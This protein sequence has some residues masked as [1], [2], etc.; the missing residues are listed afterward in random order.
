MAYFRIELSNSQ[1]ECTLVGAKTKVAPQKPLSI[2]RME[3]QA[4][5]LGRRL[6][7]S[8]S[9]A[10]VLRFRQRVFLSDSTTVL[11]WI[12]SEARQFKPFVAFRVGEILE[13]SE[14]SEWRYVPTKLNVADIATKWRPD[15]D[16]SVSN[17]WFNGPEFLRCDESQWPKRV[18]VTKT[19]SDEEIHR[20]HHVAAIASINPNP[21]NISSWRILVRSQVQAVRAINLFMLKIRN[22]GNTKPLG[23]FTAIE[24][25]DAESELIRSVQ[26]EHFPVEK[27]CLT[28]GK[29]LPNGSSLLS[30]SPILDDEGLL[31]M[32]GRLNNQE[33]PTN[34]PIILPRDH[35]ITHLIMKNMHHRYHHHNHETVINETR[36]L[37]WIPK[38]RT[39]AKRIR[40]ECNFCKRQ[41]ARPS[42]PLEAD[43]PKMRLAVGSRPFTY[44]GLD[45]FGPVEVV[46]RRR[47]E[48]RWVALF[49]CLTVRGIHLEV[50]HTLTA[51]SATMCLRRF[52]ARRGLPYEIWSDNGSN[53]RKAS[54]DLKNA[55]SEFSPEQVAM[56]FDNVRWKFIP[57]LSPNMGGAWE[58]LVRSVKNTLGH[59]LPNVLFNDEQLLSALAEVEHIINSRPLTY[60]PVEPDALEALTPNHLILGSSSGSKTPGIFP[61]NEL[62][63]RNRYI[64]TQQFADSFWRRWVLEYLPTITR[65]TKWCKPCKPI[66]I[67]DIGFI[68]DAA[69]RNSWKMG[70]VV[71]VVHGANHQV[72]QIVIQTATGLIRR[73]ASKFAVLDVLPAEIKE[74]EPQCL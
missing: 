27:R 53:F 46:V 57:P 63:I 5:V 2:P 1:A 48:K 4:A 42:Q 28:N 32:K 55:L 11:G 66:N 20:V 22:V 58:R 7:E 64:K 6:A 69:L 26:N 15:V 14:S 56:S 43:L 67:G 37:Y 18:S 51:N 73:P 45:Y 24:L 70:K 44:T 47:R 33:I 13:N 16:D 19:T 74:G 8:L 40:N 52:I 71:D 68:W 41:N 35:K 12:N 62:A 60:M 49:T 59:V 54:S 38:L 50:A 34:Y 39:L 10:H 31:R 17:Q 61:E 21:Y 25:K 36:Q 65:R 72:R 3:L 30:L 9:K 29:D 23:P